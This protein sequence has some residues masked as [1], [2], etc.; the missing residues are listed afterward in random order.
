[1]RYKNSFHNWL[2]EKDDVGDVGWPQQQQLLQASSGLS[3]LLLG[4]IESKR[5]S[6]TNTNN[7]CSP[8]SKAHWKGRRAMDL[9]NQSNSQTTNHTR[10]IIYWH[11]NNK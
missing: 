11:N 8:P 6:Y 5:L 1:M 2:K 10:S 3:R 9:T 4:T 7:D